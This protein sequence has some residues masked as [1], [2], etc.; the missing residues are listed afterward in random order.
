M[1]KYI[2][3][4][5]IF[6]IN[7]QWRSSCI[8]I[9]WAPVDRRFSVFNVGRKSQWEV[10]NISRVQTV[11]EV[12]EKLDVIKHSPGFSPHVGKSAWTQEKPMMSCTNQPK[13]SINNERILMLS[14]GGDSC[15]WSITP[16]RH[17]V[18]ASLAN[19]TLA[20]CLDFLNFCV[21][22]FK[23]DLSDVVNLKWI[24]CDCWC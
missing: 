16:W 13:M 24:K 12:L 22:W 5:N 2:T 19:A 9:G 6:N 18:L 7:W 1:C 15:Q 14:A 11:P 10:W 23:H 3:Y 4:S 20:S 17:D 8:L 21:C